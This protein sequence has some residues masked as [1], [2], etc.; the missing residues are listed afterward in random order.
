MNTTRRRILRTGAMAALSGAG[1]ASSQSQNAKQ[2]RALA[3]LGDAWH[4]V[5]PLDAVIVTKLKKSGYEPLT[6]IDYA[7]PFDDFGRYDLIVL[8]R[9][10]HDDVAFYR[11]REASPPRKGRKPWLTPAQEQKFEDYVQAGGRLFLHHDGFGYYAKDGAITRLARSFFIKHPPIVSINVSLTGK[12]PEL[13]RGVTPFTVA[14]EEYQ[15]VM[16]E[17]QTS[18]YL[19]SRSPEH[20]RAPQAWAHAYGKGKVAVFIPGHSREV[21]SHDMVQRSIQNVIDWLGD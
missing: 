16:D 6:I 3:I 4:C 9:Y 15:V 18:V 7:V 5:A 13:T 21:L 19:E 2:K 14:D 8:S 1:I 10:A 20:G 11:E 12:M 17:S